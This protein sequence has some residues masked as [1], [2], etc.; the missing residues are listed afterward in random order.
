MKVYTRDLLVCAP[1]PLANIL[2]LDRLRRK[3]GE[4]KSDGINGS[5]FDLHDDE[6]LYGVPARAFYGT[7]YQEEGQSR[8]A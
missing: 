3:Y 4:V 1:S 8:R 6:D 2:L 5:Y 7:L